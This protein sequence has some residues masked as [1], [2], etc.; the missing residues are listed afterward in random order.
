MSKIGKIIIALILILVV[1]VGINFLKGNDNNAPTSGLVTENFDTGNTGENQEFLRVL[2]NLENVSLDPA[3]L[4]SEDFRSLVDFSIELAPQPTGRTNP[5]KPIN[6][7]ERDL[8]TFDNA[9]ST[10]SF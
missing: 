5:F 4:N 10:S 2:K 9:T 1:I 6:P 3:I 8:A 7:L